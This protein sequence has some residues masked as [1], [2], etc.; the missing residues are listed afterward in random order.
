[1][2]DDEPMSETEREILS[3]LVRI[4]GLQKR[5]TVLEDNWKCHLGV[6]KVPSDKPTSCKKVTGI[7]LAGN[8]Y[9]RY[10]KFVTNSPEQPHLQFWDTYWKFYAIDLLIGG[11]IALF[12]Y[13]PI[14]TVVLQTILRGI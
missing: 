6:T 7:D 11:I 12:I 5:V 13:F 3:N 2:S 4:R 14:I 8:P 10:Y 9:V 1:M